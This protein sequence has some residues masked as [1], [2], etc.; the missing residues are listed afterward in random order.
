VDGNFIQVAR[1]T[2]KNIEEA[3]SLYLGGP[4]RLMTTYCVYAELRKL[5]PDMRPSAAFAKKLEKR[6]CPHSPAVSAAEC[7]KEVIGETNQHNYCVATQDLDLR[8][9]L[10]CIPGVPLMYINKS[11]MIMEPVSKATLKKVEDVF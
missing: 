5:G 7:I 3:L 9:Q 2:G 8:I 10:R 11:V 4:V 6:R 1:L